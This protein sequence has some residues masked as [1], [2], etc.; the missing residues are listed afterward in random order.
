MELA[1]HHIVLPDTGRE[2]DAVRRGRGR[3]L[4]VMWLHEKGMHKITMGSIGYA[5]E[6]RTVA[7]DV[8]LIP[9]DVWDLERL[10]L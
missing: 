7:L 9:S 1:C 2:G 5:F 3:N 10:P 6:Q 4:L 8:D